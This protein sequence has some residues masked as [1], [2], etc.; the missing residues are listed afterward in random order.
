M[1]FCHNQLFV[2][3]YQEFIA[4]LFDKFSPLPEGALHTS[5]LSLTSSLSFPLKKIQVVEGSKR[6]RSHDHV[7]M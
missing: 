6:F 7:M 1:M 3:V 5:I 2:T 4:P